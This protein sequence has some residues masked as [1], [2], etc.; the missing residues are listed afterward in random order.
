MPVGTLGLIKMGTRRHLQCVF[1]VKRSINADAPD[2]VCSFD[3]IQGPL[4]TGIDCLFSDRT[5]NRSEP[6]SPGPHRILECNLADPASNDARFCDSAHG[7]YQ[8]I[9][10]LA[11]LAVDNAVDSAVDKTVNNVM[12]SL[13]ISA[14]DGPR[15]ASRSVFP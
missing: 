5:R 10:R 3:G 15:L 1:H 7:A 11:R 2:V 9:H 14:H 6:P 8:W 13:T 12:V 4:P